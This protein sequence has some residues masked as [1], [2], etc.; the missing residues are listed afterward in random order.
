MKYYDFEK[1]AADRSSTMASALPTFCP[2][3]RSPSIWTI[4]RHPDENTYWRC[5][6]CGE[7]WNAS[8]RGAKTSAGRAW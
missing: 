8:R 6:G 7:V 3:C 5:R 4:A 2:A 1:T